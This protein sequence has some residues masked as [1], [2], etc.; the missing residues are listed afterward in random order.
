M[1]LGD[2]LAD[3]DDAPDD[4]VSRDAGVDRVPPIVPDLME[5]RMAH[6][7]VE[8]LDGD[9]LRSGIPPFESHRAE[10]RPWTVCREPMRW[11]HESTSTGRQ[12]SKPV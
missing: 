3:P 6:T 1:E 2:F 9:V 12:L 5:I 11:N 8:N 4:F 10:R 7:A